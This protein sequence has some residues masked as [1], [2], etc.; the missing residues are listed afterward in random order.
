MSVESAPLPMTNE[1]DKKSIFPSI[2]L[3]NPLEFIR[4]G[5]IAKSLRS[6]TISSLTN[7]LLDLSLATNQGQDASSQEIEA[8]LDIVAKL[9]SIAPVPPRKLSSREMEGTWELEFCS[10]PYLFRTSPF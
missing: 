6:G 9:E 4:N 1:E 3:P 2:S 10:Q 7:D 8:A 5:A